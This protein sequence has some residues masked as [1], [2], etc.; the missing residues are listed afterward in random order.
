MAALFA[1]WLSIAAGLKLKKA[2]SVS[3]AKW[4]ERTS[5]QQH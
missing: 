3:A 4:H 2:A 5:W 1:P